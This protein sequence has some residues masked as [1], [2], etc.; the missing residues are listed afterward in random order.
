MR[1]KCFTVGN[2]FVYAM[3][4]T[5]SLFLHLLLNSSPKLV[6]ENVVAIVSFDKMYHFIL[7]VLHMGW[8]LKFARLFVA[9]LRGALR[10]V[11]NGILNSV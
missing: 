2:Q 10:E 11:I 6:T 7:N 4:I 5:E 3:Y 8:S 1:K 9:D